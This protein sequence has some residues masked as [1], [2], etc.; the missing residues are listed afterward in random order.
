ME[1][2]RVI[3]GGKNRGFGCLAGGR[4]GRAIARKGW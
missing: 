1:L 3:E 2:T 4:G